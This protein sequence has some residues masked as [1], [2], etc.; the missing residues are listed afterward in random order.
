MIEKDERADHACLGGRQC[1][2]DREIAEIDRARHD[3]LGN[4]VALMCVAGGRI[5]ARKETH[6]RLLHYSRRSPNSRNALPLAI[7]CA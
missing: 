7:R 3:D 1:P 5:L 2:P 6:D 4:S